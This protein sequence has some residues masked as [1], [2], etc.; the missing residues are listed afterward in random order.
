VKIA[1]I[2]TLPKIYYDLGKGG[3]QCTHMDPVEV[4]FNRRRPVV[5]NA[6]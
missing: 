4:D 6:Y 1:F 5:E 3:L 2:T